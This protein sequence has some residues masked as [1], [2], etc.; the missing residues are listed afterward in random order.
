[1]LCVQFYVVGVWN[2]NGGCVMVHEY[3]NMCT[4]EAASII[5]FLH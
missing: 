5:L 2:E 4:T 1:M 3:N